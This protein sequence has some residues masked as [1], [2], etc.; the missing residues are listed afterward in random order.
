M[1]PTQWIT[2]WKSARK[3]IEFRYNASEFLQEW[4]PEAKFTDNYIEFRNKDGHRLGIKMFG[5]EDW[6]TWYENL[7]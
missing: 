3:N 2:A 1:Y 7:W 4:L 6:F 5:A